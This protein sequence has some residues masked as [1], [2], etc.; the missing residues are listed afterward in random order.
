M[1]RPEHPMALLPLSPTTRPALLGAVRLPRASTQE[2]RAV[3]T[4]RSLTLRVMASVQF[5]EQVAQEQLAQIHDHRHSLV[6][7][8]VCA[9][10]ARKNFVADEETRAIL[11]LITREQVSLYDQH[12]RGVLIAGAYAIAEEVNRPLRPGS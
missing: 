2:E 11:D 9:M 4:A 7:D 10:L 5:V 6:T 1:T 3:D 12:S 8:T